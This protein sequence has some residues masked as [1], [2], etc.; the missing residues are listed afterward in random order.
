MTYD[1]NTEKLRYGFSPEYIINY[2]VTHGSIVFMIH[3]F[4]ISVKECRSVDCYY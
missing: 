2:C 3:F 4:Y 1:A